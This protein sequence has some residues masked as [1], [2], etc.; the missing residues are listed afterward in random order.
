MVRKTL[1]EFKSLNSL[2]LDV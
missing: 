2:R 1:S